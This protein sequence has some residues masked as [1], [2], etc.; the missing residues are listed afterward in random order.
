MDN[1]ASTRTATPDDADR[2]RSIAR[3]AY[4]KYVARI[5][6]EPAPMSAD[7]PALIAAG[8]VIV[9]EDRGGIKAYMVS[10][11]EEDAHF[12]DNIAVDPEHQGRGLGRRLIEHAAM[13][14]RRLRLPAV[15]LHTNVAMTENLAMYAH[16]GFV[17]THRATEHGFQR[18]YLRWSLDGRRSKT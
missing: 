16:F 3:A 2:I 1:L 13:E 15:R 10:W 9:A 11:P 8:Y 12:I 5:G 18:V 4:F 6:R 7:F 17:E 14:A